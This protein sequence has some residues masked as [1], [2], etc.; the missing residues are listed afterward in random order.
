MDRITRFSLKNAAAIVLI[1]VLVT[2][3]GI[4]SASH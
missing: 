2:A 4:Y 3:G 1:A